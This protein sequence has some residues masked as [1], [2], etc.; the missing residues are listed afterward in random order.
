VL[1]IT[2]RKRLEEQ[3]RQSHKIEAVGRL[4]GGVAHDFNNLL[5][6]INGYS[7]LL[8]G[9]IPASDATRRHVEEIRKAGSRAAELTSHLLAFSRRQV[10][11]SK[12]IDLNATVADIDKMLRRLIGEDIHLVTVLDPELGNIRADRGQIEQVI[13][14]LAVNAREA[15]PSGGTL[16]IETA[17]VSKWPAHA[18]DGQPRR[19]SCVMLAVHDTGIGMDAKTLEHIFEPFY[20]TKPT[21][22]GTGLGLAMVY[23]I[24]KQ[25]GGEVY[26]SSELGQ[27]TAFRIYLPRVSEAVSQPEA[28]PVAAAPSG[29]HET[30]L[31]AEDEDR[32]RE[33]VRDVLQ[34]HGY[35][36]IEARNGGEALK[37][38]SARA[39][40][41]DLLL[42]DVVMPQVGGR[43]LA[44]RAMSLYPQMQ[45]L[46]MS[47]YS[48]A[49]VP[50]K[51]RRADFIQ[52]PF[53][54]DALARKV[55]EMLD[56]KV[57]RLAS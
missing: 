20:T 8:L 27:G 25:S 10:L 26:V 36:V 12:V 11:Q 45:V 19:G 2:E 1:D 57:G 16:T 4:A 56:Q 24:V 28:A 55:R 29:G 50:I 32:V 33:L 31:V 17:N 37:S 13:V 39:T 6:I 30:I 15:M 42:T 9:L 43:E 48:D 34:Q 23:G 22:K 52:K 5:T 46:F 47:G 51:S 44:E 18:L 53:T 49:G 40:A 35:T 7:D 14:N 3:V 38:L 21:G 41:V 54:P